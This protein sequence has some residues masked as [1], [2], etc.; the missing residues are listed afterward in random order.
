M[1]WARRDA[2]RQLCR[3]GSSRVAWCELGRTRSS[4]ER[5]SCQA[6]ESF[7]ARRQQ[8]LSVTI[9]TPLFDVDRSHVYARDRN[10]TDGEGAAADRDHLGSSRRRRGR[11]GPARNAPF[12]TATGPRARAPILSL[13]HVSADSARHGRDRTLAPFTEVRLSGQDWGHY[14]PPAHGSN[15]RGKVSVWFF[16]SLPPLHLPF[17]SPLSPPLLFPPVLPPLPSFRS[18]PP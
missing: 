10:P 1:N 8:Q 14:A 9:R 4:P 16:T 6:T 7:S 12:V 15:W 17:P 3:V 18:R 5:P 2:T 13:L 11:S